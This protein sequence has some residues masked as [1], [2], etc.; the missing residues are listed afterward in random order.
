MVAESTSPVGKGTAGLLLMNGMLPIAAGETAGIG[1]IP[2]EVQA[3]PGL[4]PSFSRGWN[5]QG[6]D[7]EDETS[8]P[9][10]AGGGFSGGED[11]EVVDVIS[12]ASFW[13]CSHGML[14][15]LLKAKQKYPVLDGCH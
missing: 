2:T 1:E 7:G 8:P 13:P 6:Y 11:C 15:P 14:V 10:V 9:G 12:T 3:G 4:A 5:G